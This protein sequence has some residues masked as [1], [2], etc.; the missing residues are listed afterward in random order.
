MAFDY[1]M[2]LQI[3][4]RDYKEVT[5]KIQEKLQLKDKNE[6]HVARLKKSL[7]IEE[8]KRYALDQAK[9][10]LQEDLQVTQ[11]TCE[12]L[13]RDIVGYKQMVKDEQAKVINLESEVGKLRE[14]MKQ[15]ARELNEAKIENRVL[16]LS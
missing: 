3:K 14:R 9:E 15:M 10:A 1:E 16:M 7:E 11:R 13:K 6:E 12:K 4:E 8:G 2:W 5:A